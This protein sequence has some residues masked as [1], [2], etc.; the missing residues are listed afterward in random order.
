[1]G[2]FR[3]D[4]APLRHYGQNEHHSNREGSG[5]SP[6]LRQGTKTPST[7]KRVL[8]PVVEPSASVPPSQI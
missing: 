1:M 3:P 4:V 2:C 5:D 8:S 6:H 7:A